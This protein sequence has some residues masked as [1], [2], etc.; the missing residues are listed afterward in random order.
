M[1]SK[2]EKRSYCYLN[3]SGEC[4]HCDDFNNF[5]H[6]ENL[7]L[8]DNHEENMTFLRHCMDFIKTKYDSLAYYGNEKG[9]KK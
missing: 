2:Q 7:T 6:K 8:S 3:I 4:V 5:N 1:F 9:G